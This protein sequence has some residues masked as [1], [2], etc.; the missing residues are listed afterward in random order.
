MTPTIEAYMGIA[1]YVVTGEYTRFP[2]YPS[3]KSHTMYA[4]IKYHFDKMVSS[5]L[6]NWVEL[7]AVYNN[8][9]TKVVARW[10][11]PLLEACN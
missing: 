7:E 4:G 1:E 8:G 6:F 5:G 3:P 11:S 9:T 10:D 2:G